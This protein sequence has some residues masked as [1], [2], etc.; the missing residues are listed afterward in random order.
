MN[1][2]HATTAIAEDVLAVLNASEI[3]ETSVKL[4][5]GQ[6]DRKLYEAVNKVLANAGGKWNRGKGV[7]LFTADPREQLGRNLSDGTMVDL[8][9]AFQAFYTPPTLAAEVVEWAEVGGHVCL[10]PSC[11]DG[12][13]VKEMAAQ[14][15]FS[16]TCLDLNPDAIRDLTR[17]GHRP[18]VADFLDCD[19]H[20]DI[21]GR[22]FHRIVMN[23]PFTK[24]QDVKHL[25]HAL[26]KLAKGGILVCILP[27]RFGRDGELLAPL[28]RESEWLGDRLEIRANPPGAFKDSGTMV[29]TITIK[30]TRPC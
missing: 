12:A 28:S 18:A 9:K 6:L 23:P 11:G 4:P 27:D 1:V 15:A 17:M 19:W 7:H 30:I 10:E 24:G 21:V 25:Q 22:K 8:K 29:N 3:T 16:I 2:K 5:P 14:G 26:S 20:H 13:L